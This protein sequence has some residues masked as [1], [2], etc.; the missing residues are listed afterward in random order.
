MLAAEGAPEEALELVDA[1]SDVPEALERLAEAGFIEVSENPAAD[2]L[3]GFGPLLE[4]G[5]EPLDAELLASEFLG[6][7]EDDIEPDD[8]PEA[9]TDLIAD[10][11]ATG[12]REA[13]AM[14]RALAVL[15]PPAV[16]QAAS[17]AADRLTAAGVKAP[18]WARKVG[19]PALGPCFGYS[20]GAQ[21][22]LA[23]NFAY[24]RRT[25]TLVVLID[26]QLGGGVKD[27]FVSDAPAQIREGYRAAA[28]QYGIPYHDYTHEQARTILAE[29]LAH[30]PCPEQEDQV[31]DV[32]SNLALARQRLELLPAAAGSAVP[33]SSVHRL[34]IS[35]RGATPPIWRRVEVPSSIPLLGL[36][37]VI[38]DLFEWEGYHLWAF[39]TPRGDYGVGDP[40]LGHGDAATIPLATVAGE[41]KARIGYLYDFGDSWEHDVLVEAV[42]TAEP[43]VAY[44]RCVTGRRAGPEEDSGGIHGYQYLCEIIADPEHPDHAERLEW[45]GLDDPADFDPAAFDVD[46]VNELLAQRAT[47]LVEP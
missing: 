46:A 40:E 4:P 44:P 31:E 24:G 33:E 11:E 38:Q 37:H 14:T 2:L 45:L 47:V 36:H 34:K 7:L 25:H 15:A 18:G 9:L 13:L 17:A 41:P 32:R 42:V 35:L 43:G 26:H 27:C 20:D 8:L 3:S 21:Q 12:T 1:S 19:K 16:R 22:G 6:L 23:L 10:A 39:S 29:A 30:E 28:A 5:C